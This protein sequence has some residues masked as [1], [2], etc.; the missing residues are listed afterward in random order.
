MTSSTYRSL[1]FIPGHRQ[2]MLAKARAV[3]ADAVVFDLEDSVPASEKDTARALVADI[4]DDWPESGAPAAF[5]RINPPRAAHLHLDLEVLDAHDHVGIIVPKVDLPIEL[6]AVFDRMG[7]GSRDIIVNIETPRSLLRAAD[8]ADTSGVSG[9]FL[10]AEDLTNALGMRRTSAGDELSWPRFL[11]L[12]A[13]RAAGIEA[14]D[15]IHP[16]F[17]NLDTLRADCE[18]AASYGFD[19]KFAIHPAQI[20]VINAAFTPPEDEVAH[21]RRVVEAFEAAVERGDGAVAVD[22]QMVD[23][24]VAERA[25]ALLRRA[26]VHNPA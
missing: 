16:E 10:G 12:A 1:L 20:P 23:P 22:G 5:V 4:L 8:F 25:R 14:Y 19:G 15:T 7:R 21:A 9:L 11:V 24:P 18:R 17:H 26:S 13:S 2:S 6:S 3:P